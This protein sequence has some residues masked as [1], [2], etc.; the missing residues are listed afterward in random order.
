MTATRAYIHNQATTDFWDTAVLFQRLL[1]FIT[2]GKLKPLSFPNDS[3]QLAWDIYTIVLSS[4]PRVG[5]D[6]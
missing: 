5:N 2:L 3:N 1:N 6:L 4:G